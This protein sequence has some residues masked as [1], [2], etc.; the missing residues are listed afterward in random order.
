ME[1]EEKKR[2]KYNIIEQEEKREINTN[3][4]SIMEKEEN[5]MNIKE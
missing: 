4:Y 1:Q 5:Q 2:N 3:K